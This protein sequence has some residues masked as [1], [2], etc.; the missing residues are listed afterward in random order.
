MLK[1]AAMVYV[2]I[3]TVCSVLQADLYRAWT[4]LYVFWAGSEGTVGIW[5]RSAHY[6]TLGAVFHDNWACL[7]RLTILGDSWPG[8]YAC[9]SVFRA[10]HP[11]LL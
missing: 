3:Q 1:D 11:S 5:R 9:G 4:Y 8:G 2:S 10:R 7:G 6:T